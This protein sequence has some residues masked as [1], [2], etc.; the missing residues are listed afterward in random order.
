MIYCWLLYAFLRAPCSSYMLG[1]VAVIEG[2]MREGCWFDGFPPAIPLD[3]S[4]SLLHSLHRRGAPLGE[5]WAPGGNP[6]Y[7]SSIPVLQDALA[8]WGLFHKTFLSLFLSFCLSR[9][10]KIKNT[11]AGYRDVMHSTCE[12]SAAFEITDKLKN[13]LSL[14][15][16]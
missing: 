10:F 5:R 14:K 7:P 11:L 4:W 16:A 1:K 8:G 2:A 3:P 6:T 9:R 12:R 15:F 13:F